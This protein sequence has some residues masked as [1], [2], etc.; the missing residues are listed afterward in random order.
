ML[1]LS[2]SHLT[3]PSLSNLARL[4]LA[5]LVV[6]A[7]AGP[8][9]ATEPLPED[10]AKWRFTRALVDFASSPVDELDAR[11]AYDIGVRVELL[12][13]GFS[14]LRKFFTESPAEGELFDAVSPVLRA[15][16]GYGD[17]PLSATL[18][19]LPC[20][21]SGRCERSTSGGQVTIQ[22]I[23]KDGDVRIVAMSFDAWY[24]GCGH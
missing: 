24:E 4:L 15:L 19:P 12:D 6:A 10:G 21:D 3:G 8:A 18:A 9:G 20:D 22:L 2:A 16:T 11:M 1:R 23:E 7:A 13:E 14:R 17:T 5:C